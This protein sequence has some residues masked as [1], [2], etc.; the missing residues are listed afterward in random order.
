MDISHSSVLLNNLM[1]ANVLNGQSFQK[2]LC[3]SCV[4]TYW[5]RVTC[6]CVILPAEGACFLPPVF[7]SSLKGVGEYIF[8]IGWVVLAAVTSVFLGMRGRNLVLCCVMRKAVLLLCDGGKGW[9]AAGRCRREECFNIVCSSC[10]QVD[11]DPG[12]WASRTV[13]CYLKSPRAAWIFFFSLWWLLLIQSVILKDVFC[14]LSSWAL[15]M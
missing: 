5:V 7:K 12:G 4:Q 6:R 10:S 2:V 9:R 8:C 1:N 13:P 15:L 3:V 14:F 11:S